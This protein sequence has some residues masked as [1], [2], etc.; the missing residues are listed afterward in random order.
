M[1]PLSRI[2]T[3]LRQCGTLPVLTSLSLPSERSFMP[4][5]GSMRSSLSLTVLMYVA[6]AQE[7]IL[8]AMDCVAACVASHCQLEYRF[9]PGGHVLHV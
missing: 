9:A 5:N 4:M 2:E 1:L 7:N 6:V 3:R 8:L